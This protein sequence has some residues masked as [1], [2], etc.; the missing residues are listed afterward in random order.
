[1]DG[2]LGYVVN[3]C[4]ICSK[5]YLAWSDFLFDGCACC[6]YG[7]HDIVKLYLGV[8]VGMCISDCYTF[9]ILQCLLVMTKLKIV[10]DYM[11]GEG[12]PLVTHGYATIPSLS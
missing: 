10:P 6:S 5:H 4:P 2:V 8:K 3:I 11:K 12:A 9:R 1:M 7:K